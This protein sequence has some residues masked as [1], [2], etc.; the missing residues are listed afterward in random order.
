MRV[1]CL[2]GGP[3][4]LYFAISM[5]LRDPS[6]DVVVI[7]RN[8]AGD[9]FGWGVVF[10]DQTLANLRAN[11]PASA[12]T[13]E[14]E[15]AHWDDIEVVVGDHVER[16]GGHGFIGIGR[17]RLLQILQD[18]ARALGVRLE[19][20]T[21]FDSDLSAYADYDLIVAADGINS[22][23]RTAHEDRFG[24]DIQ[25]RANK[26]IWLG[27]PRLFDAFGFL[28]EETGH[29][30]IW[31]H[32]YRFDET[33]STFIVECS[34]ATWQGLGFDTMEQADAIAACERIFA[35]HLHGEPLLTNAG[36]LRG[37]AA[38]I[39]F[40]RVL[41]ETWS[42]DNVVLLGDAAHTAHFSIGS[43]TK[44]ALEDAIKLAEVMSR[45]GV[46]SDKAGM[47]AALAE[48]Q[49]ER[50]VEVLKIQNSA[51]NSTEWFETL[52]RYIGFAPEQFAYSLL[53]RSQ[54]VSHENLRLR[55]PRWL[56]GIERWFGAR[57]GRNDD[58]PPA[59][60]MFAPYALRGLQLANRV[61][62]SP[63][64]TYAAGPDGCPS[65]F[66]LVHYGARAMGGAGLVVTEMTAV[67]ADGRITPHCPGLY[68]DA[69]VAAWRRVA[70]F[71]H[72][73]SAAKL[74]VQLGHAGARGATK[75]GF[76]QPDVP[77]AD[78][79]WPLISASAER[80][81]P[82]S[83]VPVE[84]NRADMR[85]VVRDFALAAT[86]A[87]DAG[88]DMIEIQAGHGLLLSSF[89]TPLM[90]HRTDEY[91]GS[92]ENRLR[93]P[94]EVVRAVREAWGEARPIAVRISANDWAGEAGVTP[95][96]AV[97]IAAALRD[98]GADLIDVSA[99]ET[100]ATAKPVYG[101]MFQTPFSD[102]IRNEGGCATMA[103][104]NIFEPDHVNSIL[105]AG[106]ADLVALGRPHLADPAWTMRAAAQAGYRDLAVPR[107][108][109]LGQSQLARTLQR[110]A[111]AS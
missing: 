79:G 46:A 83:Q 1:A 32:A 107:A 91:G 99:G 20:E 30:W 78:G 61:V 31:A 102:R 105:A 62:V 9:T 77:L 68:D 12:A 71:V 13:I 7:E 2:G 15:F 111:E 29:G 51:R 33:R 53:T 42:F 52:H 5:K 65:D 86:R 47:R 72:A 43:G 36:H 22:R 104:G 100:S 70:D 76:V 106:R 38:W 59:P 24:V 89:L 82:D 3:A 55:D 60:P 39:N 27:T 48:Y 80:Y 19:F 94:V 23:I 50:H 21:E 45:P 90:N 92:L 110:Q 81:K 26:F 11:D 69:Q 40:R 101:R 96:E 41:C 37:S 109:A 34:E 63:V 88:F 108:Y 93:L 25:T 84:M 28:F 44:L 95:A 74:C 16:S 14:A 85:R 97:R 87:A 35:R 4:G 49:N 18:R 57:A 73:N 58:A 56:A 64:L 67:S 10:S 75:P 8:K 66:H 54:R 98:A 17:K 6:H 103:V